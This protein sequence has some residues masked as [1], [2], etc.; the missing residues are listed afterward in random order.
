M[1]KRSVESV[2]EAHAQ[3]ICKAPLSHPRCCRSA[4]ARDPPSAEST[5][6]H[7]FPNPSWKDAGSRRFVED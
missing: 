2:G 5:S 4:L 6:D 7:L 3:Y 1:N